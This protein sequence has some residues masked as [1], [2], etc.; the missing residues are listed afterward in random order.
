MM[1]KFASKDNKMRLERDTHPAISISGYNFAMP[2]GMS[3]NSIVTI[4]S[5]I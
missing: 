4:S 2:L 3:W 1:I 5:L